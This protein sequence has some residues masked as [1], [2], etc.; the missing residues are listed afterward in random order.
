[1]LP[2]RRDS[3][4]GTNLSE[5]SNRSFQRKKANDRL[6]HAPVRKMTSRGTSRNN[7]AHTFTYFAN[8]EILTTH[9]FESAILFEVDAMRMLMRYGAH[10]AR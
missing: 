9:R 3:R 1:M 5:I 2:G 6:P 10:D 4:Q 7:L 8:F